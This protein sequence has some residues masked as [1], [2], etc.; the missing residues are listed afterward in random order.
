MAERSADSRPGKRARTEDANPGPIK[1]SEKI[2][3]DDGNLVVQAEQTQFR[4]HKGVLAKHSIFFRDL[5]DVP[6]PDTADTSV[7]GCPVVVLQDEAEAV[8]YMLVVIYDTAYAGRFRTLKELSWALQMGHKYLVPA[9]FN[10]AAER[11]Q[12]YFPCAL[13][14]WHSGVDELELHEYEAYYDCVIFEF[15]DVVKRVGLHRSLPALCFH[16]T[17]LCTLVSFSA[18]YCG[19]MALKAEDRITLL[20]GRARILRAQTDYS[21]QWLGSSWNNPQCQTRKACRQA[22]FVLEGWETFSCVSKLCLSC[23][24]KCKEAH[25][26]GRRRFWMT[27]LPSSTSSRG[28]SSQTLRWEIG[29]SR[30]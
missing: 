13:K 7:D 17:D 22:R 3:F 20:M 9:L 15:Y 29:M 19:R 24:D 26:E 6:Q 12:V 2:W 28:A 16:Y 21:L 5:K 30:D 23:Q 18:R 14:D 11:L 1:R 25:D 8:E 27:Y 10:N 4:V